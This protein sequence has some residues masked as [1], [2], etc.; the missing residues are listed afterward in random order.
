MSRSRPLTL[1]RKVAWLAAPLAAT[2][3]FTAGAQQVHQAEAAAG[4]APSAERLKAGEEVFKVACIA[5]HQPAKKAEPGTGEPGGRRVG[6][7]RPR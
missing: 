2:L 6:S 4:A 1:S 7:G 3:A 5:C